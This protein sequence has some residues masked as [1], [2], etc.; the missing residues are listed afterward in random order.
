MVERGMSI[1][2]YRPQQSCEGY[3]F[4]GVCLSTGGVHCGVPGLG[5]CLVPW[6]SLVLGGAWSGDL[7]QRVGG[8]GGLVSNMH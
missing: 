7:P 8:G 6:G 4:T 2:Y 5:G 1:N 3:V